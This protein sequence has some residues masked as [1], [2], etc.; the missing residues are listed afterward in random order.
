MMPLIKG[1]RDTQTYGALLRGMYGFY[2]PM[3]H[4]LNGH[5]FTALLPAVDLR[6]SQLLLRDL[7][8][9]G[10]EAEIAVCTK[11]PALDN[12]YHVLGALYVLEGAALGGRVIARMLKAEGCLPQNA[13]QF[14]EGKGAD[15]GPSWIS[16]TNF[17]NQRASTPEQ[18]RQ[19]VTAA[20][21]TFYAHTVWMQTL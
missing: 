7:S 17:L 12:Q 21:E 18:I 8:L 10:A 2:Q 3:E 19:V 13:F 16:F 11:L 14:F 9:L 5:T 15:T 20:N 6:R 4:A 1:A